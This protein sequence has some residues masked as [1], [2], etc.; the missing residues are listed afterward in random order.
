MV[1]VD[2]GERVAKVIGWTVVLTMVVSLCSMGLAGAVEHGGPV[3]TDDYD[4][5]PLAF[6]PEGCTAQGADILIGERFTSTSDPRWVEDFRKLNPGIKDVVTMVWDAIAPGCESGGIHL[7]A[8][9]SLA[10][11]FILDDEQYGAFGSWCGPGGPSCEDLGNRLSLDL[12]EL[13]VAPC[14]QIDAHLGPQLETVGPTG[15]YYGIFNGDHN[16]LIAAKNGGVL[17]CD[18]SNPIL[19]GEDIRKSTPCPFDPEVPLLAIRCQ[20]TLEHAPATTTTTESLSLTDEASVFRRPPTTTTTTP[21]TTTTMLPPTTTPAL[22]VPGETPTTAPA[23]TT[24][25]IP[26]TA[27]TPVLEP[28]PMLDPTVPPSLPFTDPTSP[29][30]TLPA[31]GD[32]RTVL[33]IT[34]FTFLGSGV[35]FLRAA[36]LRS[37]LV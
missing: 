23:P 7:S 28:V 12:A 14:Y 21:P 33:G 37:D 17:P 25:S 10:T 20:K 1:L 36:R 30:V 31:T 24:T 32:R 27:T 34:G 8:K 3:S 9:L 4:A 18:D 26:T 19:R 11:T 6:V 35:L 15:D 22:K 13:G 29:T 2:S 5:Y 16:M